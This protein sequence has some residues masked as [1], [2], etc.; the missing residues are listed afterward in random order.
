MKKPEKQILI[1]TLNRSLSNL[2]HNLIEHA[3]PKKY[4]DYIKVTSFFE[5]CQEL[6][7]LRTSRYKKILQ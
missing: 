6:L 7:N 3:C 4:L 1:L 5:L 2:I